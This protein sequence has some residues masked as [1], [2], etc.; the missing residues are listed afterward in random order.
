MRRLVLALVAAALVALTS[1]VSPTCAYAC[2]CLGITTKRA[3]EQSDA[4]FLGTVTEVTETKVGGERAAVLRFDVSRV[5]KGTVY[6]D[7]VIVTPADSAACGLTPEMGSSWVIFAN[8]TIHGDGKAAKLRLTT[9]LCHG[10]LSTSAPPQTLG[11]PVPPL[12]GASDRNERAETTDA[13]LTRGL[14]IAG[15]GALGLA[16]L[17]GVGLAYL[18]RSQKD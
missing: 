10:N 8:G 5:Y 13:R 16:A 3:V 7:Q 11:R 4:V 2:S 15:I 6:A 1:V 12:P 18:W 14:V 17:I 9:T